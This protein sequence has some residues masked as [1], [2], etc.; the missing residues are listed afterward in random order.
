MKVQLLELMDAL[1]QKEKRLVLILVKQT[2]I[3]LK[4]AL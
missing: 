3:L 4:F 2:Q 1:G